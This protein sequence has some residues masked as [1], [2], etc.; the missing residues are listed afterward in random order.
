MHPTVKPKKYAAPIK[1]IEIV[2]NDS[3]E[4]LIGSNVP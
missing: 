2:E 3:R 4:A 1:P